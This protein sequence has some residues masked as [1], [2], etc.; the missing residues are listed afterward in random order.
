MLYLLLVV[1][2][3]AGFVNSGLLTVKGPAERFPTGL[4]R[5]TLSRYSPLP[6]GI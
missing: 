1:A 5:Y 3:R 2:K 4:K 6:I